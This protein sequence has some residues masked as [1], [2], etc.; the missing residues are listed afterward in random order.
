VRI[1][2]PALLLLPLAVGAATTEELQAVLDAARDRQD[3]PGIS[4]AVIRRD[5]EVFAGGSGLADLA[6]GREMD[7]DTVLYAGSLSKIFTAVLTLNLADDGLLDLDQPVPGIGDDASG[8]TVRH[9]LTHSSGLVREGNFGY[10][11][12]GDFPDRT[13][14]TRFLRITE[15]RTP[16]GRNVRY[17]NIGYAALGLFVEDA[18]GRPFATLL[19]TRVLEPLAMTASGGPGPT[20]GIAP[21]YTPPGRIIPS[22]ERP[23]AGVGAQS[24]DRHLREYHDA[25][26]MTPAFGIYTTAVDLGRLARFLLGY[27]GEEVLPHRLRQQMLEPSTARRTL[28]LGVGMVNGRQVVRH[29]GWFAAHKSHLLIDL[30]AEVAAVV[31]TNGD[32]AEPDVIAEA[33]V[34]AMIGGGSES[35][36][37]TK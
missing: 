5:T 8:P 27:G 18:G 28:G 12:S 24:G 22:A 3:V 14:L 1:L 2:L 20:P 7:G 25:R 9:L 35:K 23:F 31:L 16:P 11:F 33:L 10:W 34:S 37:A 30:D 29:N 36:A 13:S 32:N 17:S 15:L 21:G 4:A 26:A 19:K 6:T